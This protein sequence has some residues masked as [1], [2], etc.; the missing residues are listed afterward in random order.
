MQKGLSSELDRLQLN[1][2]ATRDLFWSL[3]MCFCKPQSPYL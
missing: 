2:G 3:A 1:P